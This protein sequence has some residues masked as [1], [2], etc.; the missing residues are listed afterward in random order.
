MKK[1]SVLV[2]D[3]SSIYRQLLRDVLSKDSEIEVVSYAVNG[4]LALPRVKHY[5]P[6]I[7][8]L[9]QEMPEMTG[10]EFL[11][12]VKKDY[13]DIGVI[14]FSSHTQEGAKITISALEN[15]A[16]DFVT[17]P[18]FSK[19][20]D[21]EDYIKSKLIPKIK[22]LAYSKKIVP[23]K[24][25]IAS[26]SL[27]AKVARPG[28]YDVC[29]IG[30]STGGPSAL[31]LLFGQLKRKL[32]GSILIV[33]H[34][35]P[36]FTRQLAESLDI[37]TELKVMESID[38][39]KIEPNT[40]YIAQ[41]GFHLKVAVNVAQERVLRHSDEPPEVSCKPS[42]NVL[43]RSIANVYGG[44]SC[45]VIMTGMGNDGHEGMKVMNNHGSYLIAQSEASCLVYGMP[46]KPTVENL[47]SES[48]SIEEIAQKI[49]FL[50][51]VA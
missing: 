18:E 47:V 8:I 42:V 17:K 36:I 30:I 6:N 24:S 5:K 12:V 35:P 50:L 48:L 43:F 34:M 49:E 45:G 27:S 29:A 40:A 22:E 25:R 9:D 1:I 20:K 10:L 41:G 44:K 4:R 13:P 21:P 23:V 32:K 16:L 19:D 14:M 7:I 11:K 3:D 31:R 28:G 46:Q 2:V 37:V 38:G 26:T 33:Q 39:L 51:G 15:G